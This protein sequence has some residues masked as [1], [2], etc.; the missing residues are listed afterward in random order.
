MKIP[1]SCSKETGKIFQSSYET[2]THGTG[3]LMLMAGDQ[4]IEHLNND[5]FGPGIA[6]DDASPEHMLW[7]SSTLPDAA[8]KNQS[9][10]SFVRFVVKKVFPLK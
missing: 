2:I 7:I 4:K 1:L 3:K 6:P 9:F 8:I 5:F 10:V